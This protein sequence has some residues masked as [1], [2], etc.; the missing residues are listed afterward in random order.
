MIMVRNTILWA[1]VFCCKISF[2][3]HLVSKSDSLWCENLNELLMCAS[4]DI[5][6][7]TVGV[8]NDTSVNIPKFEPKIYLTTSKSESVLKLHDK[9]L[10]EGV[11]YSATKNDAQFKKQYQS[12]FEKFHRCLDM[13]SVDS[14]ENQNK[15]LI[16]YK[17]KMLTNSEDETTV[18][19]R[20]LKD[21]LYKLIVTIY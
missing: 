17:D 12:V 3:Q 6:S 11:F 9:I 10:Y 18:K 20:V 2:G 16:F 8:K 1:I 13:W 21:K 7:E 19:F 14:F 5:V 4:L 15:E